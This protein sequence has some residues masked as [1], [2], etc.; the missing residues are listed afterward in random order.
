MHKSLLI[1]ATL[2]FSSA[3]YAQ[4]AGAVS[5]R[6]KIL[7]IFSRYNASVLEN[8]QNNANYNAVLEEFLSSYQDLEMLPSRY[9]LIAAARNFDN[10]IL[11]EIVTTQYEDGYLFAQMGGSE[12]Q[13]FQTRFRKQLIPIFARIWAV[14]VQVREYEKQETR[15]HL[16]SVKKESVSEQERAEKIEFLENRISFLKQELKNLKKNPGEQILLIVDNYIE[17]TNRELA[18][19]LQV[20]Q[21]EKAQAVSEQAVE[22]DNLQIKTKNKKP[23]AK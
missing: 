9:E 20:V 23:V 16:K 17:E 4:P 14:T 8:A 21:A 22:S 7:D 13:P 18:A 12:V 11:L 2:A 10:S 1:L 5:A 19:Q 15:Q 6:E 3:L